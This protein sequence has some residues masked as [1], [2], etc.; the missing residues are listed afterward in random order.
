MREKHCS[1]GG[2]G[3]GGGTFS[4]GGEG[5]TSIVFLDNNAY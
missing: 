1:F 5:E 4:V 3:G 2:G